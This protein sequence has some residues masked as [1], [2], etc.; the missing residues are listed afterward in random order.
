MDRLKWLSVLIDTWL[1]CTVDIKICMYIYPCARHFVTQSNIFY[2]QHTHFISSFI[3][4]ESNTCAMCAT[5]WATGRPSGKPPKVQSGPLTVHW[6]SPPASSAGSPAAE[7][8]QSR[9]SAPDAAVRISPLARTDCAG[10]AASWWLC[11]SAHGLSQSLCLQE[12]E[13]WMCRW[14]KRRSPLNICLY[15]ASLWEMQLCYES[16]LIMINWYWFL[17][18]KTIL[19][20]WEHLPLQTATMI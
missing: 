12:R 8:V 20:I 14:D 19:N 4:W 9:D 3:P 7:E 15:C 17:M 6:S 13:K 18:L 1:I 10:Y 2:N 11:R 5:V 16:S